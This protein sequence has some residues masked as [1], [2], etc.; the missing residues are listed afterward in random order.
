MQDALLQKDQIITVIL[1]AI[2]LLLL[3]SSAIIAFFYL[4]R[5]KITKTELDNARMQI[6]HQ[7][8]MLRTTLLTQEE[9]RKRIAQDLHDAIS[10]KL[11]IVSLNANFLTEETISV[12]EANTLGKSIVGV[13][14]T[15]LENSRRI[16]HD[17]L[18]PSL[19][20]FGL[21]AALDELC[22]QV[23]ES[24]IIK[25]HT[26]FAEIGDALS[27]HA[28]LHMFRIVQELFS[29]TIKYAEAKTVHITLDFV[30][31]AVHLHYQDDGKGFQMM[32]GSKPKGL[33]LT[34]IE[35]RATILGAQVE[36]KSEMGKGMSLHLTVPTDKNKDFEN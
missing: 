21:G 35:N 17:L 28:S 22:D 6:E 13:T 18:P 16:A 5:K 11:N 36:L 1:I 14:K 34:G 15:I 26:K 30:G 32:E 8:E 19:E 12:E 2:L 4:S 23:Q 3:M 33:G 27:Q 10:S 7:Q 31:N 25:V 24:G 9:E 20:K 29:N